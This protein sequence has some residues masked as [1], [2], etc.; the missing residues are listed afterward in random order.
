MRNILSE[1]KRTLGFIRYLFR[2]FRDDDC[3]QAAASLTYQSLFAVVPFFTLL[4]LVFSQIRLFHGLEQFVETFI[5]E[6]IVPENISG[7]QEYLNNF[8]LK[9]ANLGT[10]SIM[11][12]V[13]MAFLM[14][15]TIE[16][17]FNHIWKIDQ[18]R[19]GLQRFVMYSVI[20][21]VTPLLVGAGLLV[22]TYIFSLPLV[23]DVAETT[24]LMKLLPFGL[25]TLAFTLVYLGVPNCYVFLGHAL[26][27]GSVTA[28]LFELTKL[29]FAW[30]VAMSSY[31]LIYGTYAAVPLFLVWLYVAWTI[32]LLGAELVKAL[33]V[34]D[35]RLETGPQNPL[36]GLLS[37]V[38]AFYQAHGEGTIVTEKEMVRGKLKI[39][40]KLWYA[41]R[42][43]LLSLD[44]IREHREGFVL[45]KDLSE[46]LLSELIEKSPW[47]LPV[48]PGEYCVNSR[49]TEIFADVS[50]Y[51]LSR[52]GVDIESLL[53]RP[54]SETLP[55]ALSETL[56]EPGIEGLESEEW[57]S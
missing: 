39:P 50:Q 13:V 49:I 27:G 47:K 28:L 52:L 22:S 15:F 7:I 26:L 40:R 29:V 17:T 34:Y 31:E 3:Q 57:N 10:V 43:Y 36:Y 37:V 16:K 24:N 5:F 32:I 12:L 25:T 54:E 18:P 30:V 48:H 46:M 44:M 19:K 11:L 1:A 35:E 41:Y 21:S 6:N 56:K 45:E 2:Q 38:D 51:N 14:L 20:L 33:S 4:I 42:D 8:L 9:A 53:K 23:V 55:G